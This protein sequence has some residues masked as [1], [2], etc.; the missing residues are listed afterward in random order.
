MDKR[1]VF[2]NVLLTSLVPIIWG[3]TYLV[4]TEFLPPD[5]PLISAMLR[6]LPAGLVILLFSRQ[7]PKGQWWLKSILLGVLNIGAFFYFLF[8]AAYH[9]PGGIAALV[10]SVQPILVLLYNVLF[11][12]RPTTFTQGIACVLACIGIAM[13]VLQDNSSMNTLGILA[14]AA[15]ALSMA[16]GIVLTKHWGRPENISIMTFTGW[17]LSFGG[18]V[19]LPVAMITESL[20]IQITFQ[21]IAGFTYLCF[22]GALLTYV[23]WFRGIEKLPALSVS[24]ISLLSPLSAALLGYI[25]LSQTLS[26]LQICGGISVILAVILIQ[27]GIRTLERNRVT[28]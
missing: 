1:N 16:T 19:L 13:V 6:A 26:L 4:T 24:F 20:P 10:M 2:G 9:L 28:K 17:Q 18:L 15:G 3:S 22:I 14:G 12:K 27:P 25:F 5:I 21:N 23:L 11:F 8:I 7:L